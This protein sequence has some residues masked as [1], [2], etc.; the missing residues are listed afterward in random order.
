M[1]RWKTGIGRTNRKKNET[2]NR[3][4]TRDGKKVLRISSIS[5]PAAGAKKK[6]NINKSR[7]LIG[8]FALFDWDREV[9][10]HEVFEN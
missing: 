9:W 6:K 5:A 4:T 10:A 7:V 8:W 2:E 1:R 3:N